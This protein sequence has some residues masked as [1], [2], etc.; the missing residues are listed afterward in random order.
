MDKVSYF[1]PT[2]V[3]YGVKVF[4]KQK[5]MCLKFSPTLLVFATEQFFLYL[6]IIL[7]IGKC[8]ANILKSHIILPWCEVTKSYCSYAKNNMGIAVMRQ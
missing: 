4:F 6:T 2:T 8:L 7:Y 3:K 1:S 5:K